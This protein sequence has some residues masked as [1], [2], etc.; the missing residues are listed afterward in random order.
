MSDLETVK[1]VRAGNSRAYG[2]LIRA[3][4]NPLF[5]LFCE[6]GLS[7][8]ET[9]SILENAF[10]RAYLYIGNISEETGYFRYLFRALIESLPGA[11]KESLKARLPV[12][13]AA[14]LPEGKEKNSILLCDLYGLSSEEAAARLGLDDEALSRALCAARERLTP[15]LPA[16]CEEKWK[17][18]AHGALS[19]ALPRLDAMG[20]EAHCEECPACAA[21]AAALA[22]WE[23]PLYR[24]SIPA[25]LADRVVERVQRE[26]DDT[27]DA[28]AH[29]DKRL[30]IARDLEKKRN[31]RTWGA[32]AALLVLVLSGWIVSLIRG[33]TTK[34][35]STVEESFAGITSAEIA[36]DGTYYKTDSPEALAVLKD[37]LLSVK[38][39][40][41]TEAYRTVLR[42]HGSEERK[43]TVNEDY[44]VLLADGKTL[45]L[46]D[47]DG[48]LAA[49]GGFVS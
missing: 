12:L 17:P 14:S 23:Q 10:L 24:P 11:Q 13:R 38:K 1:R 47:R 29:E 27:P 39:T 6:S 31:L 36:L 2:D 19:H 18:L 32:I 45:L 42:L 8:G 25:S 33:G 7:A 49:L 30:Q 26:V 28:F 44:T 41:G 16:P 9:A 48:L 43:L 34:G 21:Y 4:E 20:W 15:N 35:P 40:E 46:T 22:S 37:Y 3:Y 5:G